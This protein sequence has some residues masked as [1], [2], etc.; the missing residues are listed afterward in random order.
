MLRVLAMGL[1]VG[2]VAAAGV[3]GA[4][5]AA[6]AQEVVR[7]M[8]REASAWGAPRQRVEAE[9]E[10]LER[11]IAELADIAAA[12]EALVKYVELGGGARDESLDARLCLGSALRPLCPKLTETF[13]DAVQ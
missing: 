1:V 9:R 13:G 4:Q 11:E 5:D 3:S 2:G 8:A 12:Q 7:A 6:P 10:R